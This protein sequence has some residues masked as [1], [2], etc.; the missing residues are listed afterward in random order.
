MIAALVIGRAGSVGFKNKNLRPV[1]GRPLSAYSIMAGVHSRLVDK[2]YVSTDSE[3][4]AAIGKR[5]GAEVIMRD[6][7]LATHKALSQD[8]FRNGYEIIQKKN[9]PEDVEI[10]ALLFCNGATV[11]PGVIDQG[12]E[13][14]KKNPELDSAATVSRYNMWS[15]LRAHRIVDG[16]LQPFLDPAAFATATCDRDSQGDVYFPDCSVFIVRPRC[17]DYSY[18]VPPFPWMGRHVHPLEQWGGLDVDYEWQMPQVE[19]WLKQHGF[20]EDKTP[21]ES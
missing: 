4:I 13:I 9:K 19:F 3:A 12:I 21:Y 14:L 16:R 10:L 17:F 6:A 5:Y 20:S 8:A 11:T 2:T 7:E 1:L 18:G 15:P